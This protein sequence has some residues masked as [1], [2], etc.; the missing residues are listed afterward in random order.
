MARLTLQAYRFKPKKA[1][2]PI[3]INRNKTN[4]RDLR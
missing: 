2:I 1:F 3:P 4:H